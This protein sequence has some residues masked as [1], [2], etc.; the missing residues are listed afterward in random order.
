MTTIGLLRPTLLPGLTRIRRGHRTL[1]FGVDPGRAVLVELADERTAGILDLLDG[2]HTERQVLAGAQRLGVRPGDARELLATLHAHGLL[3]PAHTLTPPGAAP[4]LRAEAAALALRQIDHRAAG[5]WALRGPL[6]MGPAGGAASGLGSLSAGSEGLQGAG[7]ARG[8][9]QAGLRGGPGGPRGAGS[10]RGPL[11]AGSEATYGVGSAP[12]PSQ[13]GPRGGPGGVET[14]KL[15]A[16]SD[17]PGDAPGPRK[18]GATRRPGSA[19][20]VPGGRPVVRTTVGFV[21]P[22]QV[23]R[24]R[25]AARVLVTGRGRLATPIAIT[26]ARSGVGHVRPDLPGIVR[27]E[28]AVLGLDPSTVGKP[29]AAAVAAA[30]AA[31]GARPGRTKP[32]VVIQAGA[33]QPAN[34]AATALRHRGQAMLAVEIRD[35]APVIGP[36][37]Q[38]AGSPCLSCLD[39]HRRDRDEDWSEIAAGLATAPPTEEAGDLVTIMTAA[40]LGAAEALAYIDGGTPRTTDG[41]VTVVSPGDLRWRHWPAHPRCS[42]VPT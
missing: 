1:Q 22:A 35:G 14:A 36:F 5:R 41:A 26:L 23:L 6:S 9:S 28:E 27:P 13:T 37:V 11:S 32:H 40:A 39:H 18:V 38:P 33:Q 19:G 25:A 4:H 10:G 31:A 24:R 16:Q 12:G 17:R 29:R 34:L 21:T 7:P 20:A 8:P 42:C 2:A 30:V 15:D 3:V